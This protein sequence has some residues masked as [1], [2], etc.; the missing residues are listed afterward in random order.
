MEART[1]HSVWA[2]RFDRELKDVFEVQDEIAR[3]ITQA[4][5]ITLS[6]QEE[7]AIARKPTENAQAYDYYL[8]GRNYTRRHTRPNLEFAIQMFEHAIALDPGFA[9]AYAGLASVCGLFHD[10]YDRDAHWVEKGL[11]ACEQAVKLE[12]QLAEVLAARALILEAQRKYD[13]AI[14]CARQAIERKPDCEG[15]YKVLGRACFASDRWEEA[16]A[17]ANRAIEISGDD[18]N[19]YIPYTLSLERLGQMEPARILRECQTRALE[20]QLELIPEDVRARILLAV[21]Y[22]FFDKEKEAIRE[23]QKAVA[24]RPDDSNILYNAAC[25]YGIMQRKAEALEMLRKAKEVG[26]PNLDWAAR[27]P[28]LTCLH[29]D[30]EFKRLLAEGEVMG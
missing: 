8:R 23:L 9:L 14:Q 1:G 12:P 20:Q 6:P 28:D 4:L 17:V 15:A 7:R 11:A 24:L 19:I 16:A 3:S 26:F 22:A 18:Y 2:E 13:E 30:P 29:D 25:A 5:R 21:N 10:W 27:D